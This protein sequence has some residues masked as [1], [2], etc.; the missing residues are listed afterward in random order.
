[1]VIA[2][3]NG[4]LQASKYIHSAEQFTYLT[5]DIVG[6]INRQINEIA[7]NGMPYQ[8]TGYSITHN[9]VIPTV[10]EGFLFVTVTYTILF[11]R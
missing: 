9:S 5:Q 8:A 3:S 6:I 2:T 4:F 1:M 11:T 10:M 7:D